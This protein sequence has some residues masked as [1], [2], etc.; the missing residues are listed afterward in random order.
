M[1][2]KRTLSYSWIK[3]KGGISM[4]TKNLFTLIPKIDELL[5]STGL[6]NLLHKKRPK[7]LRALV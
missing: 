3:V 1:W 4:E 6:S 5:D 7:A 2:E